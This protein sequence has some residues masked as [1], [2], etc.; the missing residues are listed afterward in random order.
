MYSTQFR[1]GDYLWDNDNGCLI[2][3]HDDSPEVVKGTT[4]AS[5]S[6]TAFPI[7]VNEDILCDV[8]GFDLD[9]KG[10]YTFDEME[11]NFNGA[12]PYGEPY[13]L[14]GE[15]VRYLNDIQ[16]ICED[17]GIEFNIDEDKLY[18]YLK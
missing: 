1:N 14:K 7:A 11:I 13:T 3:Y 16:N 12:K 17:N 10:G 18:D 9:G 2:R 8:L 6:N 5:K 15:S 4:S